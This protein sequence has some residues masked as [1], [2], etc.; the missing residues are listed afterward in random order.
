MKFLF[1]LAGILAVAFI[2]ALAHLQ[3]LAAL[4]IPMAMLLFLVGF[5]LVA[6]AGKSSLLWGLFDLDLSPRLRLPI[7]HYFAT[8]SAFVVA[9]SALCIIHIVLLGGHDRFD[10]SIPH[11][12]PMVAG[13]LVFD[14]SNGSP[15][16]R[17][18]LV[19]S[20]ISIWFMAF[21][22]FTSWTQDR[23]RSLVR[24][25][26]GI[27][28]ALATGAAL[29]WLVVHDGIGILQW[30]AG[31]TANSGLAAWLGP[32][33]QE[34]WEA[35]LAAALAA[36]LALLLY[37]GLGIYG[38][39]VLGKDKMVAALIGPLMAILVLGWAGSAL[40]FF[41]GR[42]HIPLLL[43]VAICGWINGMLPWSD[44]T[45]TLLPRNTTPAPP[46]FQ[47]LTAGGRNCAVLVAS[48]GGGIQAAAWTA[49]VLEGLHSS[50]FGPQFDRALC[51]IS[52]IS[53][54]S[55]GSACYVNWL[56]PDV[57]P[58]GAVT[59][60]LA[61]AD[62]SLDE[63]SW[64]LAWPD[65]LRVMLPLPIS[66]DRAL[67]MEKAWIANSGSRSLDLALSDWN[68]PTSRGALPALIMNSTMVEVGGPL[69][70]GT[71]DA[72][73]GEKDLISGKQRASSCWW[74]GDQLHVY[75]D[76]KTKAKHKLDVPVVRAARLSATFPVVTPAARPVQADHEPH[77]MDGGFYDNYGMATLTDWLDQALEEQAKKAAP[78]N[79]QV[80]R[81]LVLQVNG[82]PPSN[83]TPPKP[84]AGRGG[85]V[86]QLID[87]VKI[88]V[89]VRTA[90][91]VSHRD[92]E[93]EFLRDKWRARGICIEDVHFELNDT[94]AP[95]SWHLMP[96]QKAAIANAW[97]TDQKVVA[98]HRKVEEFLA[99]CPP[100]AE[101]VNTRVETAITEA[102]PSA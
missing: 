31:A 43:V 64:G 44:H 2:T 28:L 30:A 14:R 5:P 61:A 51:L 91:Q 102:L 78:G 9:G 10:L 8:L 22:L 88:L 81:V 66:I 3:L 54:G 96:K 93:M 74:D 98:A 4:S 33:Y 89:N 84:P 83:F 7:R 65:L 48:A 36:L 26:A 21:A 87:P 58:A 34:H 100:A 68:L 82:F 25:I 90:G 24:M 35:H 41:L 63:V 37:A 73:G 80:K 53:G 39:L 71:S 94:D 99:A 76:P 70:L 56:N 45:Y 32:G 62:S 46:P 18:L 60:F 12:W 20:G 95:L 17:L 13:V 101:K 40:Q 47:V 86:S 59:P 57:Q 52:S 67:A 38:R 23:S 79:E 85:W 49:K 69:L 16:P 27:L 15:L 92:V 19:L 50:A 55:M 75:T 6:V 97:V 42:W 29:A 72:N 1:L 77:M 11:F